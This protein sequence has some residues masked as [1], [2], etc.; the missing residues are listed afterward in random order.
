[1][2]CLPERFR[3]QTGGSIMRYTHDLDAAGRPEW[4]RIV[5]AVNGIRPDTFGEP[6]K[7]GQWWAG[8]E[9]EEYPTARI[10]FRADGSVS[11][12]AKSG[13]GTDP[14]TA[15]E[16]QAAIAAAHREVTGQAW[17]RR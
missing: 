6:I 9:F 13:T 7:S 4:L 2:L 8:G 14:D 16:V 12:V 10:I 11:I 15:L 17:P 1:L 3:Q 5:H